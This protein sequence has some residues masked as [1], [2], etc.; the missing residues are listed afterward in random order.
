MGSPGRRF[1]AWGIDTGLLAGAA[2]LL[3]VMT[4]GRLN[5]ILQD[6]LWGQVWSAVWG[7]LLSGGDVQGAA[8]D[9]GLSIWRTVVSDIQQALLLLVLIEFLHQ[10]AGQAFAGR[11]AGKAVLDLRVEN[12]RT[13]K[14]V[15][16]RRALTTTAGGT[17]LYCLAWILLL[18]G[19][20][21]LA[22]LTWTLAVGVL[23][24]NSVPV[25]FGGRRRTLADV[26]AGTVVVPA[27]GYRRAAEYAAH[28]AGRAWAGTRSTGQAAGHA[29]RD[30]A[31]RL[32]AED[33]VR[34]AMESDRARQAQQRAQEG[35]RQA[36]ELGR[37]SA[38]K[39]RDA[40]QS[41]RAQQL[42]DK[43]KRLGGRLKNAYTDRRAPRQESPAP[44]TTPPP[45]P[46]PAIP[47]PAP[48]YD[49]YTQPDQHAQHQHAQPEPSTRPD[50]YGNG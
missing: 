25:L 49:P 12:A 9:F 5:G 21:F 10:F 8:E 40:A 20:F 41:E 18:H 22:L 33:R 37:R 39:M 4:W 24:A 44:P 31:A 47:P 30:Q 23:V 29:V 6:G 28:G 45:M 14:S 17:G 32:N 50:Q 7:L 11:T 43:G 42:Q 2:V 38:A 15:A 16:L 35:A 34:R 36:Q 27:S 1:A 46:P 3:S 13:A 19:V 26:V 48:H